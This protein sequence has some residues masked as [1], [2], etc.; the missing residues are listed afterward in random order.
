MGIQLDLF[1]GSRA[2][3][4]TFDS[5]DGKGGQALMLA[6]NNIGASLHLMLI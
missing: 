2:L 4:S 6:H 3:V 5:L 1:P